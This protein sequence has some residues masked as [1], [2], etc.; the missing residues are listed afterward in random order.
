MMEVPVFFVTAIRPCS[1]NYSVPARL[2]FLARSFCLNGQFWHRI[3][4]RSL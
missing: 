2:F 1:N 4:A 3:A